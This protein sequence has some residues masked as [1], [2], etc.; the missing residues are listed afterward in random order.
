MNTDK[1][2]LYKELTGE[3]IEASYNVHNGLG[4]GLLEK[5]YENSLAWE[6]ELRKRKVSSQREFR[7]IYRNKEV[8]VYYADLVIEDKVI[9]EIKSVEKID[10]VHRA[11]LLNYLRI[12]GLKVGLIIN[13]ARPKLEYERLVV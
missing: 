12:S 13:F 8:G 6:I 7:V 1:E 9:V 10:N 4:C 2:F 5:I 11:Q 3:I